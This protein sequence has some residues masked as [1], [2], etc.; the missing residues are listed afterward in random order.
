MEEKE[1]RT[2]E[3][4]FPLMTLQAWR[5]W[6][7]NG[8]L[9]TLAVLTF[10]V[11]I[12]VVSYNEYTRG[13]QWTLLIYLVAYGVILL[14]TFWSKA[15]Y[16]FRAGSILALFYGAGLYL[17]IQSGL[18][19]DYGLV[20][21]TFLGLAVLLFGWR[22]GVFALILCVLSIVTIG[23]FYSHHLLSVPIEKL[24]RTNT[25]LSSW[26]STT[27]V[28][29]VLGFLL[30]L[31]QNYGF[32]YLLSA[33]TRSHELT[34]E[35]EADI[36]ER[37]RAKEALQES[38]FKFRSIVEQ[39]LDGIILVD[40]QGMVIEYNPA[41]ER[42]TGISRE[43]VLGMIF[44]DFHAQLLPPERKMPDVYEWIKSAHLDALQT[45]VS[46]ILNR[47]VEVTIQRAD[48]VHREVSQ[49]L[50]AI[51]TN[52][53]FRLGGIARDV[54]ERKQAEG[55]LR[56]A[57]QL[58]EN[59]FQIS[60]ELIAV[61]TE[62]E[63]RYLIVND[64]VEHVTGYLPGEVIGHTVAEFN[65]WGSQAE[66]RKMILLLFR[67]GV[68]R[69]ME[70]CFHRRSG[71]PF[72]ALLSVAR[73]EVG[74]E[75][76][77][78]TIVTDITERKLAEQALMDSEQQYRTTLE[79]MGEAMHV[80]DR[81]LRIVLFNQPFKEWNR[82]LKLPTEVLGKKLFDVFSFLPNS[83]NEEYSRV[84]QTGE[85]LV[86]QERTLLQEQEIFTETRKIPIFRE[87]KVFQVLTVIS[88]ITERKAAEDEIHRL[89]AE[90]EQRVI[91]RTAQL[92][93][94]T[95]EMEAFSYSVS[96]DLRAPLR[97]IDGFSRIIQEDYAHQ[98]P[99][100]V[101]RLLN[102]VRS[103]SQQMGRLIDGLLEFSRLSRQPLD[104][105]PVESNKLV[106]QAIQTLSH[107]QEGRQVEL[108]IGD[109]PPCQ[110]DPLLLSQV[111]VNLLANALKF[112]RQRP[113]ARIEVGCNTKEN[114]EPIYYVR[115]NGIGFDMQYA[116]KLFGVFQRLHRPDEFE[117]TGVGLALVQRI[118]LRHGG[119]IWAE[120]QPNVGATFYFTL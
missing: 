20:L 11:I 114:G 24:I 60:P 50:F 61:I 12:V 106:R 120:A 37:K 34:R 54:T 16:L 73:V 110:G 119:R 69:N 83:V 70:V 111:W 71:E 65:I 58:Y 40:E 85:I 36:A 30:V 81:D 33:L 5:Q 6:L 112:T 74:K 43:Q 41:F 79:A 66:R 49:T 77:L 13:N 17:M 47:T 97:A 48:G 10:P 15:P 8:I 115:D 35:L 45:G 31:G 23:W 56:E 116:D 100:E 21:L 82:Q 59:V 90:L 99:E 2:P 46:P 44:W 22:G 64:A 18:S 87:G 93:A 75:Q 26:L 105:Q 92:Q 27:L 38:E 7:I 51:P 84:F 14:M 62:A 109:L 76:C 80:V 104:K 107:E 42:I 4:D 118:I 95:K 117:G 86:T 89:N 108:K 68:V 57:Q 25:E 96:H 28:F 98:L 55:A 102:S 29:L 72:T 9:K 78:V 63:G 67:Q 103:N 32:R 101:Q 53:G 88:N 39:S 19:G 91:D 52:Q 1:T 94:A 113:M 3:S